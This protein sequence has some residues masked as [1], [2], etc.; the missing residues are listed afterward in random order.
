MMRVV[1][2]AWI[3]ISLASALLA[4][5][6]PAPN[7][8]IE[9]VVRDTLMAPVPL[10]DVELLRD[11]AVVARTKADGEG[12]F[13]F[14]RL[15]QKTYQIVARAPGRVP[16]MM[17]SGAG[18]ADE[19]RHAAL[20]LFDAVAVH[21]V[22]RDADGEPVVG[23]RL[24]AS[25]MGSGELAWMVP[26]EGVSDAEGRYRLTGVSIGATR[27]AVAAEGF[28]LLEATHELAD[29]RELDLQLV[30]GETTTL[31]FRIEGA[32]AEQLRAARCDYHAFRGRD[33]QP[34]LLPPALQHGAPDADGAWQATGLPRDMK[35]SFARVTIAG[36][37]VSPQYHSV[38][39]PGPLHELVFQVT[40]PAAAAPQVLPRLRGRLHDQGGAALAGQ[41]LQVGAIAGGPTAEVTTDDQGA[42]AVDSPAAPGA[43]LCIRPA[44][45]ELVVLQQ[46]RD[47]RM[48][49]YYG[50]DHVI[51]CPGVAD[52]DTELDVVVVP[53]A[54]VRGRLLGASG[55]PVS[56]ARVGLSKAMGEQL[57]SHS[58]FES[59]VTDREGRFEIR[60]LNG[61]RGDKMRLDVSNGAAHAVDLE[62]LREGALDL[63]DLTLPP[64]GELHGIV[65]DA[66][67]K[68]RPGVQLVLAEMQHAGRMHDY[69]LVR[70]TMSDRQG[71]YR[72]V[73]LQ[74]GRYRVAEADANMGATD[75]AVECALEVGASEDL[76]LRVPR[77]Q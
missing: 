39:E 40:G 7:G 57:P 53:A 73:E 55:R 12:H 30:S 52:A 1:A 29:D 35:A 47:E 36:A 68:P 43:W 27:F 23:A 54:S 44:D 26:A 33:R 64:P 62:L 46:G 72:F 38:T 24:V 10:A 14:G 13:V 65:T 28:E 6:S 5:E 66:D 45:D 15:E 48:R 50:S 18:P 49:G 74:P 77:K 31:R 58:R 34:I 8:R 32:T 11:D 20:R 61:H 71:R 69:V 51:R 17:W 76:P 3:A 21:G 63:G 4:Q 75:A 42:F 22:V 56:G 41:R 2:E 70:W 37:V 16:A 67:G 60:R 59:V 9:G 25:Q 19:P